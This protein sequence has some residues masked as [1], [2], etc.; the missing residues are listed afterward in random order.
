M[1]QKSFISAYSD[2]AETEN[3]RAESLEQLRFLDYGYKIKVFE[4]EYAPIG[5]DTEDD[6]NEARKFYAGQTD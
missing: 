3:E 2:M 5:I 4:T 6:L 1:Y